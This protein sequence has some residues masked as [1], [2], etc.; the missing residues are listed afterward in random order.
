MSFQTRS[1][2][3]IFGLTLAAAAAA[4]S[5]G[6]ATTPASANPSQSIT[7]AVQSAVR[8]AR[9]RTQDRLRAAQLIRGKYAKFGAQ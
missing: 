2:A 6:F 9:D 8:D 1:K 5:L 7:S 3:R 4:V